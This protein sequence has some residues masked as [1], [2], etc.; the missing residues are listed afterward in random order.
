MLDLIYNFK[1]ITA[2]LA[3]SGQPD[4]QQL[5]EIVSAGYEVVMNLG[6]QNTSYSLANEKEIIE[7]GG[8]QYWHIPVNFDHPEPEKYYEF[9]RRLKELQHKKVFLH[10]AANK[11]VS[12]FMALFQIIEQQVPLE[13]AL[14]QLETI[15]IPNPVWRDFIKQIINASGVKLQDSDLL[16]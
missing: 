1:Q 13:V 6:L 3:S 4:E 10:C 12:V 8:A 16:R 2:T 7:S 14:T 9:A 5:H 11:R 15:W